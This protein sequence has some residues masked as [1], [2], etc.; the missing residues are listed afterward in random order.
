MFVPLLRIDKGL[1]TQQRLQR[2][3]Q[4]VWRH[5]KRLRGF[6]M[7]LSA[8]LSGG[9]MS[10]RAQRRYIFRSNCCATTI[11]WARRTSW[12][13]RPPD[14][15]SQARQMIVP[16]LPGRTFAAGKEAAGSSRRPLV[17][18]KLQDTRVVWRAPLLSAD[19]LPREFSVAKRRERE[20]QCNRASDLPS[21]SLTL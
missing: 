20:V 15:E 16:C 3:I 8:D 21:I 4:A 12:R 17:H 1:E 19:R 7:A 14:S 5:P 13:A 9:C 6:L 11:S 10:S 18:S 2:I